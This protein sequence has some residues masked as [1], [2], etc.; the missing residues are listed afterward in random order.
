MHAG[1]PVTILLASAWSM[2]G[3]VRTTLNL[4]GYLARRHEVRIISV[5]RTRDEPFFP[6]PEGVHVTALDDWRPG[7]TPRA[8]RPLRAALTARS[9]VLVDRHDRLH[10]DAS[11]WTDIAL[12]RKLRRRTGVLIGTRPALNLLAAELSPPGLVT[13][14]Q[15]H[16]HLGSHRAQMRRAFKRSYPRL[17][18]LVVLTEQDRRG[19]AELLPDRPR[20]V[21]IPNTV[22]ADCT[23]T[24]PLDGTTVLAAGRITPQKGFDMLVD[25]FAQL[26]PAY[27]DWRLRICGSGQWQ[28]DLERRIAE[29]RL[30]GAITL[31]GPAEPLADEMDRAALFVLSS[32]FEGFPLVLIEAMAKGLAVVA[33][34]CPTGPGEI[35]DDHR[36][37]I[38]VAPNDVEGLANGMRELMDDPALRRRLGSAAAATARDYTLDVVGPRWEALLDELARESRASRSPRI[39]AWTW[40]RRAPAA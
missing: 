15:E 37:G 13:I 33:F 7:A 18:A 9:S 16:M 26:P 22:R 35:I 34:D 1:A 21:R 5:I 23:G 8:L 30:D 25:A 38:L 36:N 28:A 19:Y 14:G 11:L 10:A 27:A 29:H 12:V 6:F 3:T 24:A 2:G 4:A 32:R 40:R 31:A 39:S 17:D 20:V